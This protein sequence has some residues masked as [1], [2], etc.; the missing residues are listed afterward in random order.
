MINRETWVAI[1]IAAIVYS[2]AY[3]TMFFELPINPRGG[4][5]SMSDTD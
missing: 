5:I 4:F 1:S 3:L 2:A